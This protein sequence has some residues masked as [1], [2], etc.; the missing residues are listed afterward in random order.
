ML[1]RQLSL[2]GRDLAH[3]HHLPGELDRARE[4]E[5]GFASQLSQLHTELESQSAHAPA[6]SELTA[7]IEPG[8][9][10]LPPRRGRVVGHRSRGVPPLLGRARR[11]LSRLIRET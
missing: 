5:T 8:F 4:L 9:R 10:P 3:L 1:A 7:A 11:C 6:D 2:L